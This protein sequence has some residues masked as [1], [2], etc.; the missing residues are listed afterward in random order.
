MFKK[1]LVS[2][3]LVMF[4]SL[5]VGV[6]AADETAT[7]NFEGLSEGQIVSILTM[8]AGYSATA[9]FGPI[10]VQGV[11]PDLGGNAAMI[12]DSNCVGGCTGGDTD[13]QSNTGNVLIVTENFNG[14]DPNDNGEGGQLTL[15]FANGTVNTVTVEQL[16]V[17]D[18]EGGG[19][20]TLYNGPTI[21]ASMPMPLMANGQSITMAINIS[22]VTHMT[23]SFV[24]SGSIDNVELRRPTPPPPPPPP[25][26]QGC[27][28]G[29]WKNHP[30]SWVG[31]SP[32]QLYSDVFG[33]GP[34]IT[35]MDALNARGG[36]EKRF[37]RQSTAALLSEAHPGVAYPISGVIGIV[38]ANYWNDNLSTTFDS[39]NN[40]GCPL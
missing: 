29:Y 26:E 20:V 8:G 15:T 22:N 2:F 34:A 35:L 31:Y 24:E 28:L 11:N 10:G 30:E 12:F 13:L 21:L 16:Q 23:A 5:M 36:H 9:D 14:A 38:Q 6:V 17:T 40:L 4:F 3:V 7:V 27:T 32:S 37:L 39:A 1:S 33:V 25:G 19:T 18:T